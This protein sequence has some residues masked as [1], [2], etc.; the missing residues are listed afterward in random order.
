MFSKL[1]DLQ[2]LIEV[3]DLWGEILWGLHRMLS[4]PATI[5][6]K[7]VS[8]L[9]IFKEGKSIMMQTYVHK[10]YNPI[11]ALFEIEN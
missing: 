1:T 7:M 4:H 3:F 6:N 11:Y 8:V 5:I 9:K 10:S 2:Q